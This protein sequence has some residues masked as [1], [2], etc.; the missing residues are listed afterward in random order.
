MRRQSRCDRIAGAVRAVRRR[1]AHV[2]DAP[3]AVG[4]YPSMQTQPF[5]ESA[6]NPDARSIA[7]RSIIL[8]Y[9]FWIAPQ[10]GAIWLAGTGVRRVRRRSGARL[11]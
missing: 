9:E 5:F 1:C 6:A 11:V 2:S 3:P 4:F 10:I 8:R 7:Y